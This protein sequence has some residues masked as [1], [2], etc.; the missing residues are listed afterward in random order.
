VE[1]RWLT[2]RK[3]CNSA[4]IPEVEEDPVIIIDGMTKNMRVRLTWALPF[5]HACIQVALLI[6]LVTI[7]AWL[8]CMLGCWTKD[9]H[10]VHAKLRILFGW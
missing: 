9:C 2:N 7:V 8:A 3:F 4:H 5:I 6:Y 10:F 1:T